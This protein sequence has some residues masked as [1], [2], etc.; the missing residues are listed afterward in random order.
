MNQGRL[1]QKENILLRNGLLVT[2]NTQDDILRGDILI[3]NG[4]IVE[5]GKVETHDCSVI[6]CSELIVMPGFVQTHVHLCQTLFRGQADDLALLDWLQQKIWP[7]EA[8]MDEN[9]MRASARLGIAELIKSGTTSILDMGSVRHYDV[10]FDELECSGLRAAGG[11]CLMDHPETVPPGLLE[12]TSDSLAACEQLG[13][14]WHGQ[15]DGRLR[16]AVCPRFAISCTD[17]LLSEASAFAREYGYLLH[18]HASENR[19][20]ISLIEKRAGMGN[21]HFLHR[22]GFTGKD[23]TLAHCIWLSGTEKELMAETDTAIAHCPSSNLKLASGVAPVYD[24]LQRGLRIGLGADGAP[25]NNNLDMFME[26]RLAALLQKSRYGAAAMKAVEI[27]KM[28][29]IGGAKVL[30]IDHEI[31]SLEVGK[32]ADIIGVVNE[33]IFSQPGH[34]VY[35]QLVYAT[36]GRDIL[37]SIVDGRILMVNRALQTIDEKT[38]IATAKNELKIVL[39]RI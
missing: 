34:D 11:K 5:L 7:F 29:T 3:R 21:I 31:G 39:D 19:S 8:A 27:V 12:T 10:V 35:G 15:D 33:S 37:L 25:C 13:K 16:Y 28:A 30:S 17:A 14:T 18:T 6:D 9:A 36:S 1:P 22:C 23:V 24:Y 26:M 20:E 32:K 4:R 2:L 38:T